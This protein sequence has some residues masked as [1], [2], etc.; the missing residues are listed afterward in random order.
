MTGL[1][2]QSL[3]QTPSKAYKIKDG[4]M[5]IL[6]SKNITEPSLD[7]FIAQYDLYDLDLK[8][9]KK[10]SFVDSLRKL[11]WRMEVNNAEM[12]IISK[13][14]LGG[15]D[16]FNPADKYVINDKNKDWSSEFPVVSSSVKYGYNRF[17]NKYPFRINDSV[18][19][20]YLRGNLNARRVMLSG[21]FVN[22]N[23]DVLSM[24]KTDSGWIYYVKLGPGKYWYK[25]IIDGSWTIDKDNEWWEND[26]RGNDN[27]VYFKTNTLL[28]LNGYNNAKKVYL[29]GSFNQWRTRELLMQKTATGWILPMYIADGTHTYRYIADGKWFEDPGNPNKFRNEFNEYN[30]VIRMGKPYIFKLD[31]YTGAK[32]VILFGSFNGWRTNELPMKKTAKGWELAYTLGPG[33]YE[34]SFI[35]DGKIAKFAGTN[36]NLTFVIQPNY[37]FRLKGNSNAKSVF[38]GGD[39]NGWSPNAFPMEK[40]G[41]EWVATVHLDPG[42]HM[43]KFVVDG[44]WILDP[45]NKLWEQNEHNSGNSVVWID[46]P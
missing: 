8:S 4:K 9:L 32:Q 41:D 12:C 40:V 42:K 18:V 27:S 43:Y 34:Y 5:L 22:W 44:K 3:A 17:K 36:G 21:S 15:E 24:T 13:P 33:N 29:S 7:S 23:P 39:F 38:L 1:S 46:K 19:T 11:G 25:F 30:S 2:L 16:I 26:G 6:L 10:K 14:L 37:T 35:I 28:M 45:G 20:F 31:D